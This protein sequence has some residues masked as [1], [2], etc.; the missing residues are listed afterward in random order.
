MTNYV[1]QLHVDHYIIKNAT[2]SLQQG[3][4]MD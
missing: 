4:F 2:Q 1:D 3:A